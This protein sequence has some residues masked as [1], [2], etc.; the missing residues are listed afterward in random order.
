MEDRIIQYFESLD[1]NSKLDFIKKTTSDIITLKKR[2]DKAMETELKFH[3]HCGGG[4]GSTANA[5]TQKI[6]TQYQ[7]QLE[8]LKSCTKKL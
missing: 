1:I 5:R 6:A 8:F 4:A 7:S 3:N 2:M